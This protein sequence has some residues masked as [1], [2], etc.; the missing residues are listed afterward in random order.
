MS[1][2]SGNLFSKL[3]LRAESSAVEV[4]KTYPIFGMITKVREEEESGDILVEVN[5]AILMKMNIEDNK[6]LGILKERAFESGIF[7]S[8][9]TSIGKKVKADCHTVIF[10]KKQAYNA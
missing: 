9:V 4:G 10:G 5:G 6:M 7:I 2:D 3:G 1:P 8:K